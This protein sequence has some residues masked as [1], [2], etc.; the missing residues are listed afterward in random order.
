MNAAREAMSSSGRYCTILLKL[1]SWAA[2]GRNTRLKLKYLQP[3]LFS[4][5]DLFSSCCSVLCCMCC[6][7]CGVV[8]LVLRAACTYI[9]RTLPSKRVF[10]FRFITSLNTSGRRS[11]HSPPRK[12][13]LSEYMLYVSVD[14]PV[15]WCYGFF[16]GLGFLHVVKSVTPEQSR[17]VRPSE[18]E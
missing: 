6:C 10:F 2:P 11:A 5:S 1:R 9:L 12:Y 3:D 17:Y 7:C 18:E 16:L 4:F 8:C 15:I 14:A 13:M